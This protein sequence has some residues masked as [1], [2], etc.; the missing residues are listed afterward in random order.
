MR[1]RIPRAG[2][3]WASDCS[4]HAAGEKQGG[5]AGSIAKRGPGALTEAGRAPDCSSS[6][7]GGVE[8]GPGVGRSGGGHEIAGAGWGGI[9]H[10]P[11]EGAGRMLFPHLPGKRHPLRLA[12]TGTPVRDGGGESVPPTPSQQPLSRWGAGI[13]TPSQTNSREHR[14]SIGDNVNVHGGCGLSL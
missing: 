14:G 1:W 13:T 9:R 10:P 3:L 11:Q 6:S 8:A 4:G 5:Q 2:V 12:V 7:L